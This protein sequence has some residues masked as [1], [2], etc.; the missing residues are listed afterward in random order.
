MEETMTHK[1]KVAYFDVYPWQVCIADGP[2]PNPAAHGNV[3]YFQRCACGAW[4]NVESNRGRKVAGAWHA[5]AP[6]F[7]RAIIARRAADKYGTKAEVTLLL[8]PP[9]ALVP[10]ILRSD[11]LRDRGIKAIYC[12]TG[13]RGYEGPNSALGH[14]LEK[15]RVQAR[16]HGLE[17]QEE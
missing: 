3:V 8:V 14:A 1:H 11:V 12:G 2:C 10:R 4:R 17:A 9:G 13:N 7:E 15:A 6:G 5:P 16:L